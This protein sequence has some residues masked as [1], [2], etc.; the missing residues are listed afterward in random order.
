MLRNS[1]GRRGAYRTVRNAAEPTAQVMR[2]APWARGPDPIGA[3]R[4]SVAGP[5]GEE[6]RALRALLAGGDV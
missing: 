1:D 3:L 6:E 2:E 4:L 5:S